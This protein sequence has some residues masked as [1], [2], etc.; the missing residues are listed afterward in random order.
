[1]YILII[2]DDK[3]QFETLSK[4]ILE[5]RALSK[6]EIK[7]IITELEFRE[8]FEEIASDNPAAIVMDIML[9]WTTKNRLVEPPKEIEDEGFYRA[10]LRCEKL[11]ASDERTKNIPIIIYTVLGKEDLEQEYEPRPQ[12]KY[13]DKDF[14]SW[15]IEKVIRGAKV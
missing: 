3:L 13:V 10:G 14:N 12:V 7:R 11:L 2:E 9:R 4:S 6:Y 15:E 1:M 5:N 8:R